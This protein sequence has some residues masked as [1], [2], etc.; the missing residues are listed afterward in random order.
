MA[1][2]DLPYLDAIAVKGRIYYYYRRGKLRRRIPGYPG[3]PAF[4]RAYEDMHAAAQAADAKAATAAGVLPGSMRA[5]I[6]AYRKSPEWSEKQAS[7]KR[8]YEKAMKPLEGLFGHLPVKTLPREFVFALRD[9]YAFK[10]SVE[11]APPVKTPSRANRM[12]AVLSLLLSWAVDRGWR[13]DNPALRPKRLKTGVGYRSW[14]DVELDQVL[15][16]ETT[17]AQV[18]LAILLAVGTGQRGQDLVAM[19]WAAFDGSAVEVVQLKTGAKV[20]VPLHA[21]ARVALSS[22]PKTATTILTR[23]D[24]KPWMLDHFRHLMAKA[25]KDAG[26]EGLVTHG[27]RATAARWMA[28]AGCSEREIMSVTGHTTSNMVS[29]YVR[30]AEQ[31]TRAKGAARKVERHQQRNMNRTPSAKPKILDC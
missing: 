17:P 25:I 1:L 29:R 13:K 31:K 7:T 15:N 10:P 23:P 12:V 27:L 2:I 24:G 30:E 26:L 4:L 20:W 18:R 3:E 8:D 11:G 16:A 28:E 9:R 21:R 14:T 6:I 5:L 19:T 22:A